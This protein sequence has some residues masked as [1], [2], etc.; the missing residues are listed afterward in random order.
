MILEKI[1]HISYFI[2]VSGPIEL[3]GFI[4]ISDV[5]QFPTYFQ[6]QCKIGVKVKS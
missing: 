4:H 5:A 3:N 2:Y 6:D 1:V